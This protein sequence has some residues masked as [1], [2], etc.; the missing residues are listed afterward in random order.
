MP[1]TGGCRG[2]EIAVRGSGFPPSGVLGLQPGLAEKK[3][4]RGNT[5]MFWLEGGAEEYLRR[6]NLCEYPAGCG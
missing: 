1:E 4:S 6:V 3:G 2:P 5:R